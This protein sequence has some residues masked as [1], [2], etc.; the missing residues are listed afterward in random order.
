MISHASQHAILFHEFRGMFY[1]ATYPLNRIIYLSKRS[2]VLP[3]YNFGKYPLTT[4]TGGTILNHMSVIS[5]DICE[6]LLVCVLGVILCNVHRCALLWTNWSPKPPCSP[7]SFSS[8]R[9]LHHPRRIIAF[10]VSLV[11]QSMWCPTLLQLTTPSF[12]CHSVHYLCT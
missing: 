3:F 10:Q 5:W 8:I 12:L 1:D 7:S 4:G 6:L 11:P 2:S 9:W